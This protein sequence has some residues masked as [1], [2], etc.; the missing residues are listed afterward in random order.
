MPW[1]WEIL[2][3]EPSDS[4]HIKLNIAWGPSDT[5]KGK[6]SGSSISM[7]LIGEISTEQLEESKRTIWPYSEC[8]KESAEKRIIPYTNSCYQV[9]KELSTLRRY[10]IIAQYE[11]VSVKYFVKF[12]TQIRN[13]DI[14]IRLLMKTTV[15]REFVQTSLENVCLV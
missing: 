14:I 12:H 3:D 4:Y 7:N 11:N 8:K 6:C 15:T 1:Q 5:T 13:N 10:K 2:S 9:S